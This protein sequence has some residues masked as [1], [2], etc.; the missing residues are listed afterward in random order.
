MGPV[1]LAAIPLLT[2][3]AVLVA[4]IIGWRMDDSVGVWAF[5]IL[6]I[7]CHVVILS[8]VFS[9]QDYMGTVTLYAPY[10]LPVPLLLAYTLGRILWEIRFLW[11]RQKDW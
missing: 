10:A 2:V 11:R 7:L 3:P 8:G 1:S 4:L 9:R 5:G 6:L